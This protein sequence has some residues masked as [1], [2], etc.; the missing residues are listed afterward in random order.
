MYRKY[1][2]KLKIQVLNYAVWR[3]PVNL[4]GSISHLIQLMVFVKF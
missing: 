2:A 1:C 3:A 4:D